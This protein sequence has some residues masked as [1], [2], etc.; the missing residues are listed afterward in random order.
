M[1]KAKQKHE[2]DMIHG[3][4]AGKIMVFAMT[5]AFSSMLQQIF[6]AADLAVVGRFAG[7]DAMAAVGSNSAVI[8][9]IVSLFVGLSIGANVVVANMLGAGRRKRIGDAVHTTVLV[10]LISGVILL[11]AGIVLAKPVLELMGAPREV[12]S[13]AVLYLRIYFCGMPAITVYNF[14][15]AILRAK[16]DSSRPFYA[17]VA[18]GILNVLLNLLFVAVFHLHVIGVAL[19]T[20]LSNIL[21]A[22]L[23]ISFLMRETDEFRLNL[24]DLRIDRNIFSDMMRIGLPAGVQ[25]MVFS[26]S[27]VIIQTAVNSL[28]ANCIA[29]MAAAVNFEYLS[30]FLLNGFAQTC[31]TFTSQNYG[32]CNPQRCKKVWQLCLL[33]GTG[34]DFAFVMIMLLFRN[35]LILIFTP[36]PEVIRFAMIRVKYAFSVHFLCTTYEVTAGALRGM[37]RSLVPTVI[38]LAG[39]CAFRLFYVWMVFP[40]YKTAP[41]LILVYPISWLLTIVVMH[42]AYFI[43]RRKVFRQMESIS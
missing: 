17:L 38:S 19:A 30:F 8:S 12:M 29:G 26:F 27:N 15:A 13:L 6:N 3:P 40:H 5:L 9:L 39:T 35:Q 43:I 31:V 34:I 16:G 20:V 7:S 32:A 41:A 22:G 28:G 25:G 4:L 10:A 24:R 11:V 36:D 23:T 14:V 1:I 33:L 21:S 42:T 2:V 37:N 18:A